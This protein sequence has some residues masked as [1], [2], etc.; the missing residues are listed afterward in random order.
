MNV[1][2]ILFDIFTTPAMAALL[3]LAGVL[4]TAGGLAAAGL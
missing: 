3:V 2:E 1:K 4:V